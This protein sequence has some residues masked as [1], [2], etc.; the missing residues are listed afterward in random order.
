[1]EINQFWYDMKN[2]GLLPPIY[3]QS[4]ATIKKHGYKPVLWTYQKFKN[5]PKGVIV[6]NAEE[7]MPWKRAK[8]FMEITKMPTARHPAQKS[9]VS[10]I[11]DYFRHLLMKKKGGWYFDY[12]IFLM[13]KLDGLKEV[14]MSSLP[15]R[16]K[17]RYAKIVPHFPND[18]RLFS[19]DLN[20]S[21]YRAPKGDPLATKLV[22][23]MDEKIDKK[24]HWDY[25][26][27]FFT[28]ISKIINDMG[29][30]KYVYEPIYFH[31]N[32]GDKC[33]FDTEHFGY[34]I[35]SIE[36]VKK[37]T[38]TIGLSGVKLKE[39]ECLDYILTSLSLQTPKDND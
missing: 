27:K 16:V 9:G 1:M 18:K 20:T 12:D 35:P 28:D 7:I 32:M 13:K 19:A 14:V 38:Y 15:R 37:K 4:V 24:Q 29:Y 39:P 33:A 23:I 2:T 17:S 8:G 34:K 22:E 5:V 30:S 11:S 25:P 31:P 3:S 36:E 26:G 10:G 6:K 21:V